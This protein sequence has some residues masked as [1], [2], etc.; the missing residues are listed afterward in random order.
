ME[1]LSDNIVDSANC[2]CD[3][4]T[5]DDVKEFIRELRADIRLNISTSPNLDR[6]IN[7]L[8]GGKLT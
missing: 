4:L 6:I 1:S 8:A 3:V 2:F 5:T 7:E